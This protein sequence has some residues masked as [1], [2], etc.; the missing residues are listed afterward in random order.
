[1]CARREHATAAP[2]VHGGGQETHSSDGPASPGR[3]VQRATSAGRTSPQQMKSS[4]GSEPHSTV[5][6]TAARRRL[7]AA[8]RLFMRVQTPP[9]PA[10]Q[11][12]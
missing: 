12:R 10:P 4:T 5:A 3:L 8:T 2:R 6:R 11:D 1:M 7:W 9:R